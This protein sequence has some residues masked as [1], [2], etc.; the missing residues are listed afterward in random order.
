MNKVIQF[1]SKTT[2]Y[3][4]ELGDQELADF[5]TDWNKPIRLLSWEGWKEALDD[6]YIKI[7]N[8]KEN[9]VIIRPRHG[10]RNIIIDIRYIEKR[11]WVTVKPMKQM[12]ALPFIP[13]SIIF[14]NFMKEGEIN[15][16]LLGIGL[17]IIMILLLKWGS[18]EGSDEVESDLKLK[19]HIANLKYTKLNPDQIKNLLNQNVD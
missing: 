4:V 17:S 5:L 1:F 16:Y 14:F 6:G 11:I 7:R 12:L 15:Y 19:F 2:I 3:E 9:R 13:F 18:I 10:D 8:G